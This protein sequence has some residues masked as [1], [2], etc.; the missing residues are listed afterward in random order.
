MQKYCKAGY[1]NPR[2]VQNFS[3][4]AAMSPKPL[5]SGD[6]PTRS[7]CNVDTKVVS[8]YTCC[9]TRLPGDLPQGDRYDPPEL[10]FF[11]TIPFTSWSGDLSRGRK[12]LDATRLDGSYFV[13]SA[14]ALRPPA[15]NKEQKILP[16]F[17]SSCSGTAFLQVGDKLGVGM[18]FK[19]LSSM[20][21][22]VMEQ[23][24]KMQQC[25]ANQRSPDFVF[26]RPDFMKHFALYTPVAWLSLMM[27]PPVCIANPIHQVFVCAIWP[28]CA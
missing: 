24:V 4:P 16:F 20:F 28:S 8:S 11:V 13:G 19:G 22:F 3:V 21:S 23:A 2:V 12:V 17:G 5:L 25:R 15:A 6:G 10:G 26:A 18:S 1:P 27:K 14:T 7:W 9:K